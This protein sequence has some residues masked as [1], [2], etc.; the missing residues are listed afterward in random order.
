M[1]RL[2]PGASRPI[3]QTAYPSPTRG[4][5]LA[6][7]AATATDAGGTSAI[8]T[9]LAATEPVFVTV[10]LNGIRLPTRATRGIVL[11]TRSWVAGGG[12]GGSGGTGGPGGAGGVGGGSGGSG[13]TGGS[14]LV[15]LKVQT[16]EPFG[17]SVIAT[18]VPAITAA[19]AGVQVMPVSSQSSGT[20]SLTV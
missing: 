6:L 18:C 2:A 14:I 15:S 10:S 1:V 12:A 4:R 9:S 5:L 17:A 13:G 8:F 19:V 20:I 16:T 11:T 3:R 7:S